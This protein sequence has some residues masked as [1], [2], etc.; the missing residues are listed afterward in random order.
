MP[1]LRPCAEG[2]QPPT[3]NLGGEVLLGKHA[4]ERMLRTSLVEPL[5]SRVELSST[6]RQGRGLRPGAHG[7]KL[8]AEP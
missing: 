3:Q 7:R 1:P 6:C 2:K 5:E 4:V 8:A